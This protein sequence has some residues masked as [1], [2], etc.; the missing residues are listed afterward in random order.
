MRFDVSEDVP[1]P[2]TVAT[3]PDGETVIVLRAGAV[4][5]EALVRMLDDLVRPDDGQP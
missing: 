2:L 5:D 4:V 1:G 3:S